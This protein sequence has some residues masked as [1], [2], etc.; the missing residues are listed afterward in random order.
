MSDRIFYLN[1]MG[2]NDKRKPSDKE[3]AKINALITGNNYVWQGTIRQLAQELEQNTIIVQSFIKGSKRQQ[4]VFGLQLLIL[5]IDNCY[6]DRKLKQK[7]NV[8]EPLRH[9][10][11][12]EICERYDLYPAFMYSTNSDPGDSDNCLKY[13]AVFVLR[14]DLSPEHVNYWKALYDNLIE[15]FNVR[16]GVVDTSVK[17][18]S[19]LI[20]GGKKLIYED[21]DAVISE[22]VIDMSLWESLTGKDKSHVARNYNHKSAMQKLRPVSKD[23]IYI[24]EEEAVRSL[25]QNKKIEDLQQYC[26]LLSKFMDG[27]YEPGHME[28]FG[29]L[30]SLRY[31]KGVSDKFVEKHLMTG[32]YLE[33]DWAAIKSYMDH[34]GYK[35]M[36]CRNFN[37]SYS[38]ECPNSMTSLYQVFREKNFSHVMRRKKFDASKCQDDQEVSRYIK[39]FYK[40]TFETLKNGNG[41]AVYILKADCG[42]GK[43]T[44]LIDYVKGNYDG[45]LFANQQPS[46]TIACLTYKKIGEVEDLLKGSG[47]DY[48]RKPML[49]TSG[50]EPYHKEH[51]KKLYATGNGKNV[52]PFLE[53]IKYEYPKVGCYLKHLEEYKESDAT[54]RITTIDEVLSGFSEAKSNIVYFDE[55]IMDKLYPSVA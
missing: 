43:T 17:D 55:D 32:K 28:V 25:I 52:R 9:Q 12:L 50:M 2:F 26:P 13:R 10:Q 11:F 51:I 39:D 34:H 7:V 8:S 42:T 46:L 4:N 18:Y 31:F 38:E 16:K 23:D 27:E 54:V 49:E 36:W 53:E 35:P 37:C 24:E 47:V 30:T 3:T 20:F 48:V 15:I 1:M 19:K 6:K 44:K 40:N 45:Q 5:D 41:N 22:A 14:V 33:R 29:L 21:Y